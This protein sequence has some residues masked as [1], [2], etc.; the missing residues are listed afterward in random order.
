MTALLRPLLALGLGLVAALSAPVAVASP[1]NAE[2]L[3]PDPLRPGWSGGLDGSF[4]IARGNLRNLDVGGAGRVQFQTLH[5]ARPDRP[6]PP[7]PF[8]AQRVFVT[9]S[10]RFAENRGTPFVSQ[11]FSHARWTAMWHRRVGSDV[12]AQHQL[13]EFLRLQWRAIAGVGVRVV[14]VHRPVFMLWGGSGP[15]FEHER[16]DVAPGA[17]DAPTSSA[18]RWTNYVTMRVAV[19]EERL[20]L[21]NTLYVQPRFDRLADLRVL[22]EFEVLANVAPHFGLGATFDVFHDT[23]P[24]TAVERTDL[25]LVSTVRVSF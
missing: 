2:V 9:T 1:V 17:S 25:R 20:L 22:E 21:Q 6:P 24:P 13:N 10:G 15:M 11:A 23:A 12:F 7:L 8:L 4:A 14:A 18:W 5:A 3:R 19:F 16:I